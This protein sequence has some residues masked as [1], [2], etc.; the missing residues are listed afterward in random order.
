[1]ASGV[2]EQ[3]GVPGLREVTV[4]SMMGDFAGNASLLSLWFDEETW[5]WK[6]EFV[7][8][9]LGK[10]HIWWVI[11]ILDFV[12]LGVGLV[13]GI[14]LVVEKLQQPVRHMGNGKAKTSNGAAKV[15][16][17]S[18]DRSSLDI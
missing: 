6:F 11:H 18:L 4:R 13:Y 8:C 16:N 15:G 2:S 1:V 17:G 7:N 14:L 5:D 10:Q 3:P 9:G 12:M